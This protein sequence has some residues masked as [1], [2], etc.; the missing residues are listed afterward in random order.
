MQH[1]DQQDQ[2]CSL[3]PIPPDWARLIRKLRWI[4]LEKEAKRLEFAVG[5]LRPEKLRT[6]SVRETFNTG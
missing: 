3:R 2:S 6:V 1:R 4:G 5:T